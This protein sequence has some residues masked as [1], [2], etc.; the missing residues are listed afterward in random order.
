MP[1]YF[2]IEEAEALLPQ[3]SEAMAQVASL[4]SM[5]DDASSELQ[6]EASRIT[7]SGGALPRTGAV[8]QAHGRAQALGARLQEAVDAVQRLGCL[9]KDLEMGL[10][11]F[12]SL[13]R[14]EEVYLCWKA[15]EERIEFW[16][17]IDEGFRGRKRI[18][19][20]FRQEHGS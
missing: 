11:D 6:A 13:F 9:V 8:A 1:R 7:M 15:G 5:L 4:K 2:R 20:E 3:V 10:V 17:G 16:H 18:D 12:P 14:G 19:Q